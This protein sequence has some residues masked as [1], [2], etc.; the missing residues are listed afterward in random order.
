MKKMNQEDKKNFDNALRDYII[1]STAIPFSLSAK[2]AK[3]EEV[4][5]RYPNAR[6]VFTGNGYGVWERAK[7]AGK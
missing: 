6:R 1:D 4:E 7:E 3:F 2:V 5:N